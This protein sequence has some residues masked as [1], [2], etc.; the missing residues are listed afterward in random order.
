M[1]SWKGPG[2]SGRAEQLRRQGELQKQANAKL[3]GTTFDARHLDRFLQTEYGEKCVFPVP[4][5][6]PDVAAATAPGGKAALGEPL[7]NLQQS[8][9]AGS[10]VRYCIIPMLGRTRAS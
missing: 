6:P 2:T 4:V 10:N 1:E 8:I 9:P 7:G 3:A 5:T